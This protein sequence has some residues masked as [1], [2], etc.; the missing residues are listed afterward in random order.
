MEFGLFTAFR[1]RTLSKRNTSFECKPGDVRVLKSRDIS[2]DGTEIFQLDGYDSYINEDIVKELPVY[3]YLNDE[4]VYLTPN[5]TYF[6]RVCKKPKGVVTDGSIAILIPKENVELREED[7]LYFSFDEYRKFYVIARNLQTRSINIDSISV[8]WFG[9]K[10]R[11]C[12]DGATG[13]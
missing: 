1:D 8:F 11:C 4:D 3:A 10:K 2:D 13:C 5:M 6:P 12:N 9:R 7:M